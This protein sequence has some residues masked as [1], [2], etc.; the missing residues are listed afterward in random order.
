MEKLI[1]DLVPALAAGRGSH[2]ETRVLGGP[3]FAQA[4]RSKVVEEAQEVAEARTR[5]ALV[6]ELADLLEVVS[7][8]A[9]VEGID[10]GS[11]RERAE[12]K[13]RSHGGFEERLLL[14]QKLG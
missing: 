10:E 2:L 12:Q 14:V 7:A 3:E 1:R 9:R 8:L 4:L 11:V 6:E 13:R 5:E